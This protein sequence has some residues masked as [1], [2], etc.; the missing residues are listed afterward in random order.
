MNDPGQRTARF[1][2]AGLAWTWASSLCWG[3][4]GCCPQPHCC[5]PAGCPLWGCQGGTGPC[6]HWADDGSCQWLCLAVCSLAAAER[7][8]AAHTHPDM[9]VTAYGSCAIK[10]RRRTDWCQSRLTSTRRRCVQSPNLLHVMS[11]R[12]HTCWMLLTSMCDDYVQSICIKQVL[13]SPQ[14]LVGCQLNVTHACT[15]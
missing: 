10:C 2:E 4:S 1:Q 5:C 8:E 13:T 3:S 12:K 14:P 7:Q 6:C 9:H 15:I 11:K